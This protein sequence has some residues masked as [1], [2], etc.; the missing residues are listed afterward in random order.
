MRSAAE[1]KLNWHFVAVLPASN[2]AVTR[3]QFKILP[4]PDLVVAHITSLAEL[5]VYTRG[6]DPYVGPL[7]AENADSDMQLAATLPDMITIDRR[8]R[9]VQLVD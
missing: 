4:M 2:A 7:E 9:V 3:D 5:Q 8:N 1:G 6:I